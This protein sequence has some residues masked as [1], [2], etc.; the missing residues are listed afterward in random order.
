MFKKHFTLSGILIGLVL[1][2]FAAYLY[3]GGSQQDIASKGFSMQH[4]YLCNLFDKKAVD[5]IDNA[6][7]YFAIAGMFI[8]CYGLAHFFFKLS[9]KLPTAAFKS[10]VSISGVASMCFAFLAVTSYHDVMITIASSLSLLAIFTILVALYK[11][12]LYSL[13]FFGIFCLLIC[14]FTNYIYYTK[15]F[16]ELLPVM[17]KVSFAVIAI[18]FLILEYATTNLS[19]ELMAKEK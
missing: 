10:L 16:L 15:H 18:W 17:Q 6:G 12:K 2:I 19:F 9:R 4:N 5:G 8:L 1:I 3:P 11:S 7:R 13:F 14:Y